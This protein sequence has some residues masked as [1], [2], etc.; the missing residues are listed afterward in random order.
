MFSNFAIYLTV[1]TVIAGYCLN[2]YKFPIMENS[3]KTGTPYKIFPWSEKPKISKSDPLWLIAHLGVSLILLALSGYKIIDPKWENSEFNSTMFA[4]VHTLFTVLILVNFTNFGDATPL[5][6][7]F[8]NL[9]PIVI[10]NVAYFSN[11]TYRNEIYFVTLAAP[12]FIEGFK[13]LT[14]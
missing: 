12:V 3:L 2:V 9:T 10:M 5:T 8:I 14:R 7:T 13:Y 11:W 1:L 4:I 6:A